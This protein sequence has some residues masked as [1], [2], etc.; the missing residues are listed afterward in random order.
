MD[1]KRQ[2]KDRSVLL[3][4]LRRTPLWASLPEADQELILPKLELLKAGA[5]ETIAAQGE[6]A[7]SLF[8]LLTGTVRL[9]RL[10]QNGRRIVSG[11]GFGGNLSADRGDFLGLGFDDVFPYSIEAVT[12]AALWRFPRAELM[13]LNEGNLDLK[14]QISGMASQEYH[15]TQTHLD[16]IMEGAVQAKLARFLLVLA[17]RIGHADPGGTKVSLSMTRQDIADH[18]WHS[19]ES[20]SR[21]FTTL[22]DAE[23]IG[24]QEDQPHLV[25]FNKTSLSSIALDAD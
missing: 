19:I 11:F 8:Y 24:Y 18:L 23:L 21:A 12:D 4:E 22:R 16:T 3:A 17:E 2:P 6:G 10:D 9:V 14:E 15:R 1:S 7:Q 5:N 25:V 20:I 13:A